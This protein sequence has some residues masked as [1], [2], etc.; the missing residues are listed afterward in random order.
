MRRKGYKLCSYCG[1]YKRDTKE[2]ESPY[3]KEVHDKIVIIKVCD[4]CYN[5]LLEEI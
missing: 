5:Q 2:R 1:E 3:Y 4:L